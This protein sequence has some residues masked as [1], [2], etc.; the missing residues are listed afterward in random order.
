MKILIANKDNPT[1]NNFEM[2]FAISDR[3]FREYYSFFVV[4][5]TTRIIWGGRR[6]IFILTHASGTLSVYYDIELFERGEIYFL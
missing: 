4:P 5:H 1:L 2:L 3:A 6:I